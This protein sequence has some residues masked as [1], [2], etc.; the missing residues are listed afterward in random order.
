MWFLEKV[1]RRG[2][3][4]GDGGHAS[5]T[6][7]GAKYGDI[8]T[9]GANSPGCIR[10]GD[11]SWNFS[12]RRWEQNDLHEERCVSCWDGM[13]RHTL[14][15]GRYTIGGRIPNSTKTNKGR[16]GGFDSTCH[17]TAETN[18]GRCRESAL[19][20]ESQESCAALNRLKKPPHNKVQ[21]VSET[22]EFQT[23]RACHLGE[24]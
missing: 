23:E 15:L 13:K 14:C 10:I 20:A 16:L 8:A 24:F 18:R 7:C 11:V 22:I 2:E 17:G 1:R 19:P 3:G 6:P 12:G 21:A 9:R 4:S 5:E